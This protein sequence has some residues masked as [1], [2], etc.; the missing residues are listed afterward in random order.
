MGDQ[1]LCCDAGRLKERD[2]GEGSALHP[3]PP[4]STTALTGSGSVPSAKPHGHLTEKE[5]E[6][7]AG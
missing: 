7:S 1:S 4:G 5:N 6:H 3:A 2:D